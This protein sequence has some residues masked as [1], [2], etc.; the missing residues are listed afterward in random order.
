MALASAATVGFGWAWFA[1]VV[2]LAAHVTEAALTDILSIYNPTVEASR[3]RL[4]SPS[5]PRCAP[6]AT[7]G[8]LITETVT[9]LEWLTLQIDAY[10]VEVRNQWDAMR[11]EAA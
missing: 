5:A 3:E 1:S 6:G 2:A 10:L 7:G 8:Y 11:S 9:G 4:P